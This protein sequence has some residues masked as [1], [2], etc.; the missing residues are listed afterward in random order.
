LYLTVPHAR[1]FL[2]SGFVL[3]VAAASA[4]VY[5]TLRTAE[6]ELW[7]AH[8]LEVQ[9]KSL[10]LQS[11]LLEA[12]NGQQ[13][14]LL[15]SDEAYLTQYKAAAAAA[16][17]KI[18]DLRHLTSDNPKHQDSLQTLNALI[19]TKIETLQ[20]V[21]AEVRQHKLEAAASIIKANRGKEQMDAIRDELDAF[22]REEVRVLTLRQAAA[23][24]TRLWSL[25][26]ICSSLAAAF[27][28]AFVLS[29]G[30]QR[31]IGDLRS[32][33]AALEAEVKLRRHTQDALRQAHKMEAVGQLTGGIAHDFNNLLTI[34]LG[35]LDTLQRRLCNL[36]PGQSAAQL[37]VTLTRPAGLAIQ[38]AR[39][40]AQLTHQLLAFSRRQP[41]AVTPLDLNRLVSSMIDLL[42]RTLGETVN[43][44]TV[45]A[46]GLWPISADKNELE[47]ALINLC[48]NARDAMPEGGRLTIETANVY[49]GEEDAAQFEDVPAGE[50]VM[51]RV[52]D[53]GSGVPP[54][55]M[56]QIF[57]PFFTTK[58]PGKGSG[59][60]LAMV[61]GLVKQL[62]GH[63]RMQSELDHGTSV[64]IY[65]PR[66][67]DGEHGVAEPAQIPTHATQALG[68][69]RKETIL[70][71]EDNPGVRDYAKA[72]LKEL[73]YGV[74]T[75]GDV[76]EAMEIIK[77]DTQEIDL[78]F[79]D[80]V[81]PDA[82][83]RVLSNKFLELRPK[84]PV[85]FT[86]GYAR[87]AIVHHG[88]LDPDVHLL[89]KPYT[90]QDL[91]AKIQQ[92]LDESEGLRNNSRA[93][94]AEGGARLS[95]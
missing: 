57:E 8:S 63:I 79:T 44:Q 28:F 71:V 43:L 94:H 23:A 55:L 48:V 67:V 65:L 15:T 82:T 56:E 10:R 45:L 72:I 42:R 2:L 30:I 33:T 29:R 70:L 60:G 74:I 90:Q 35:N 17:S 20:R 75:A 53:T 91:A 37:A 34:I 14:Y 40:A 5:M 27:G 22:Y 87:D 24:R 46:G 73:G 3:V 62:G 39:S 84:S 4:A 85:L 80:V 76:A 89:N 31:A 95:T 11:E 81:L 68:A 41:L 26:A 86:T 18:A 54:D 58:P 13:G 36:A 77:D 69:D 16:P 83:G 78:L 1:P 21:I 32:Q 19:T 25:A 66:L 61:H 6:A 88:R 51:L 47:N 50:Y 12:E 49:L 7:V 64:T 38:G 9:R 92:T 52:S 59:L 93:D